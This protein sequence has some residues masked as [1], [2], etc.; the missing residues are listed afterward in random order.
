MPLGFACDERKSVIPKILE[1]P[2]QCDYLTDEESDE[3]N[4]FEVKIPELDELLTQFEAEDETILTLNQNE[5]AAVEDLK[6]RGFEP[7]VRQNIMNGKGEMMTLL[8]DNISKQRD[9]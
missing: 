8:N 5:K 6:K 9:Q 4:D 1:K 3:A 2:D 7:E